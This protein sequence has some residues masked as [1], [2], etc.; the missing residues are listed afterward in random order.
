MSESKKPAPNIDRIEIQIASDQEWDPHT[1][2]ELIDQMCLLISEKTPLA[3]QLIAVN[4]QEAPRLRS[5]ADKTNLFSVLGQME[6]IY[7]LSFPWSGKKFVMSVSSVMPFGLSDHAKKISD[8]LNHELE[9]G[10]IW[11]A[12]T[13]VIK[14]FHNVDEEQSKQIDQ[15]IRIQMADS[16]QRDLGEAWRNV[17]FQSLLSTL[18][19]WLTRQPWSDRATIEL[20]RSDKS[21]VSIPV[22]MLAAGAQVSV[23]SP[24]PRTP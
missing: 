16:V 18:T 12:I 7:R 14:K 11:R 3:A 8:D 13:W 24:T 10:K 17:S 20:H 2:R 15:D 21:I 4:A 9:T 5:F 6:K 23:S 22:L 1:R 19:P